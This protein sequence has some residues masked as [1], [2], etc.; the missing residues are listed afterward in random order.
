MAKDTRLVMAT[1]VA[2]CNTIVDSVDA[3]RI[4]VRVGGGDVPGA[5][6]NVPHSGMIVPRLSLAEFDD[7]L[8]TRLLLEGARDHNLR[9][10]DVRYCGGA[11]HPIERSAFKGGQLLRL[12]ADIPFLRRIR[13][14]LPVSLPDIGFHVVGDDEFLDTRDVPDVD[15]V[16]CPLADNQIGLEM[17]DDSHNPFF[18]RTR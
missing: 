4:I 11:I 1:A 2:A 5:L 16:R 7:V 17:I 15:R 3:N 10:I 9:G 8:Q 18:G 12:L 14:V 6:V 13:F